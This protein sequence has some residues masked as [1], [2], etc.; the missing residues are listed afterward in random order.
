MGFDDDIIDIEGYSL[1]KIPSPYPV[2]LFVP[3]YNDHS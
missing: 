3:R 2:K 1:D